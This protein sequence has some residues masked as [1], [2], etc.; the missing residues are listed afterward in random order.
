MRFKKNRYKEVVDYLKV[1]L[2]EKEIDKHFT[3]SGLNITT[4]KYQL[5]RH[6]IFII[7]LMLLIY[8]RITT[9]YLSFNRLFLAAILY[10]VTT[11]VETILSKKSPFIIILDEL[12]KEYKKKKDSEVYRAIS[13][14]KNLAIAQQKHPVGA[15]FII[16]QLSKFANLTRPAYIKVLSLWRLGKNEEAI[17]SFGD[18]IDTR[19]G[20]EFGNILLKLDELNPAEFIE[21]LEIYQGNIK[22]ERSTERQKRNE[23]ISN[24]IY[25]PAV[26]S[27]LVILLN[28]V[29]VVIF[30]D[31][32]MSIKNM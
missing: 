18:E 8:I 27:S 11:P 20:R 28:F 25:T 14:L 3:E 5:V 22:N 16:E 17:Q 6:L 21:Q 29:V 4:L 23:L 31:Q 9:N 15:D 10:V 26:I 12:A 32:L 1:Q 2:D 30:V 24:I 13:Q 19:L 7:W